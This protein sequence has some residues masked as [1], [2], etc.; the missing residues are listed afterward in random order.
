[1]VKSKAAELASLEDGGFVPRRS[2]LAIKI[3]TELI[4]EKAREEERQ[5]YWAKIDAEVK[6]AEEER[7]RKEEEYNRPLPEFTPCVPPLVRGQFFQYLGRVV[8]DALRATLAEVNSSAIRHGY[9]PKAVEFE[10]KLIV[11]QQLSA[12]LRLSQTLR[13]GIV[14]RLYI[15]IDDQQYKG[16]ERVF[17][18]RITYR[19][20]NNVSKNVPF[21]RAFDPKAD[22]DKKNGACKLVDELVFFVV[23]D[24]VD[25][26]K[27]GFLYPQ[28]EK[29][30]HLEFF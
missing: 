25:L 27:S 10:A 16:N 5:R 18:R 3:Q 21:F 22:T 1:M 30:I 29:V 13:D 6:A 8:N 12:A 20:E 9:S 28:E 24:F 26:K 19:L 23:D 17:Q 14:V 11:P 7:K 2:I 4:R 15:K